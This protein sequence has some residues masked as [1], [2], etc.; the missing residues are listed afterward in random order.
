MATDGRVFIQYT[1]PVYPGLTKLFGPGSRFVARLLTHISHN[2]RAR[3]A[4]YMRALAV[5]NGAG[6][7]LAI[8]RASEVPRL[9]AGSE[10]V[11]LWP[12]ANGLGWG[13]VERKLMRSGARISVLSGR[14]RSFELTATRW[15]GI[16][17]R[18]LVP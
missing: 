18:R 17:F 1:G 7:V 13:P 9:G 10:A 8:A 11:L 3:S 4:E 15:R 16:R 6:S 14:R 12:D 2:G 5:A